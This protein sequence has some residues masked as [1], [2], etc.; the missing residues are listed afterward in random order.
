MQIGLGAYLIL[1]ANL[2]VSI[3][4]EFKSIFG[5]CEHR[6][7]LNV[8]PQFHLLLAYDARLLPLPLETVTDGACFRRPSHSPLP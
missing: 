3:C 4:K 1:S 5:G 7:L 8:L 2:F 6:L